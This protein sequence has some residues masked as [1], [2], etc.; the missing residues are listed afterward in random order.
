MQKLYMQFYNILKIYWIIY[1]FYTAPTRDAA[2]LAEKYF[3][4]IWLFLHEKGKKVY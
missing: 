3:M 1:S 2:V 4:S